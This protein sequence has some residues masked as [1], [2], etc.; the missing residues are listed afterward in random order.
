MY[1][2]K[3]IAINF[4]TDIT[5]NFFTETFVVEFFSDSCD[6]VNI[7]CYTYNM[8]LFHLQTT[9]YDLNVT[10]EMKANGNLRSSIKI[11]MISSIYRELK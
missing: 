2:F 10:V 3:F 8:R 4:Q 1:Y 6:V 9:N 11:T 5:N 7:N